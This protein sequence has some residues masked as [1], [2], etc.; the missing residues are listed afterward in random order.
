MSNSVLGNRNEKIIV[1][2]SFKDVREFNQF[3]NATDELI[4]GKVLQSTLFVVFMEDAE[5]KLQLPES[6]RFKY[7]SRSDYNIFGQ[8]KDKELRQSIKEKFDTLFVFGN[9]S[10]KHAKLVNKIKANRR[11]VTNSTDFINFDISINANATG[12]EQIANFAK[13]TLEKIQA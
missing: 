1:F 4:N 12:V 3:K 6:A 10:E 13:E 11:I 7:L 9:I 8:I 5:D 2:Y